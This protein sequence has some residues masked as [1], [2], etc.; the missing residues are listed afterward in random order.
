MTL[1][2]DQNR[3][4]IILVAAS[5]AFGLIMLDET[6]VATIGLAILSAVLNEFHDYRFVFILTAVIVFFT[7]IAGWMYLGLNGLLEI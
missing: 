5:L 6:V 3:K 4:W 2:N 1:I 7:L